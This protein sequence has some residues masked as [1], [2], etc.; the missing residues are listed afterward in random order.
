MEEQF[1][2]TITVPQIHLF[3]DLFVLKTLSMEYFAFAVL[4]EV[5]PSLPS[6]NLHVP[7]FYQQCA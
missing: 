4:Q 2:Y 3:F 6:S 7:T 1:T 5:T